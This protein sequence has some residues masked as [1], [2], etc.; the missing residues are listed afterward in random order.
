LK[1]VPYASHLIPPSSKHLQYRRN[2]LS[3]RQNDPIASI[4]EPLL[5]L[6]GRVYLTDVTISE[7]LYSLVID[8]GSSDTWVA[9]SA[10]QCLN[11]NTYASIDARYCGFSTP[12]DPQNSSTWSSISGYGFEVNY[13]GGEFLMGAG[14]RGIGD[15]RCR[16]R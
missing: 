2:A 10:F 5:T 12:F 15:R 1:T 8:T 6:G 7:R 11:P 14:H 13:T 4:K 9:S 16:H 3:K